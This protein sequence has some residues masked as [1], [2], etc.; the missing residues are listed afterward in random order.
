MTHTSPALTRALFG[1]WVAGLLVASASAQTPGGA[2]ADHRFGASRPILDSYI[3]V[4]K[5]EVGNPGLET[6]AAMRGLAGQVQHTYTS[7]IKGFS[8]QLPPA[9]VAALQNNPRVAYIE[10]DQTV[11]LNQTVQYGATW[12]LDRIDQADLPLG[13]SYS[14][15]TVAANVRAYIIDTGILPTHTEFTG[16]VGAGYTAIADGR[17]TVD[18]NGHGTHVAGTVG[19]STWGVAK[20]VT[21]VPV[22]VLNCKGSGSNSGVIA[23]VDWVS[24]QKQATPSVPMVANMSLGGGYSAALN[25]AV[26]GAVGQG[27]TMAV[28][29][30]NSNTDACTASPASEPSAITVGA[31]GSNDARASYSNYGS[32]VD[33]FAP[34]SAITSAWYTS[35][36]ATNT[37]SGT[38]MASPHVAGV[39]AL[40]ASAN[41]G[42]SPAAIAA[43]IRD[44]ATANKVSNAGT[45][46]PNLLLYALGTGTPS[47]PPTQEVWVTNMSGSTIKYVNGWRA[48]VLTTVKL[49]SG[50]TPVAGVTV[51]G[52]YAPG[53]TTSCITNVAG[54][55]TLSSGLFGKSVGATKLTITK[56]GGPSIVDMGGSSRE[57]TITR[58]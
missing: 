33:V 18:C 58:P 27:V 3:V 9:A 34:G 39:A 19:G 41:T 36:T 46:S 8:A 6:A 28:A 29:A 30:G 2:S 47:T 5:D 16:R 37:I 43:F 40:V 24:A 31:T 25:T 11:S 42:A 32:C 13:G 12:G 51:T 15:N 48:Q 7:A 54:Q 10:Q 38:S 14:Y 26:A 17:G 52:T 45:G 56:L 49:V 22:R 57:L 50:D 21:L 23:G 4:F 20:G 53:S 44:T 55:C 1:A 35:A